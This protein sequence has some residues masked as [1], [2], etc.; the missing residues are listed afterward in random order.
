MGWSGGTFSRVHNFSA[1]ASA[2]IQAQASRFDAEF[3]E[4]KA[5]LENCVTRDGQ[6]AASGNLPMGGNKH[7][8]VGAATS[9]SEYLRADQA[10][11]QTGIYV[12]GVVSG[13]NFSASAPVFPAALSD[14]MKISVHSS[15][16]FTGGSA[17]ASAVQIIVNG[18]SAPVVD[19]N[20]RY[21]IQQTL[22][23]SGRT[24]EFVYN[25]ADA[26]WQASQPVKTS[27]SAT[28]TFAAYNNSATAWTATA[29]ANVHI[30]R[31]GELVTWHIRG[32]IISASTSI[33]SII[34]QGIP[35]WA[36][37]RIY[38]DV[39]P[40]GS[41]NGPLLRHSSSSAVSN[42]EIRVDSG[43]QIELRSIFHQTAQADISGPNVF[44]R[45][46][47]ITFPTNS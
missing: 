20:G 1:D 29:T 40:E 10:T 39:S 25:S 9:A 5:G 23:P 28:V 24:R 21:P 11:Q 8:G 17:T 14:G 34:L 13:H 43:D 22:I 4:Y 42:C 47:A 32:A 46:F 7:T 33:D 31:Q 45:P 36:K 6:N 16:N 26:A 15:A 19:Y 35:L 18:L 12:T 37:P 41:Y 27:S 3:D 44:I 30:V 2:G 38:G